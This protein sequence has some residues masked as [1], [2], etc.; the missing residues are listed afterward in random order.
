MIEEILPKIFFS[1]WIVLIVVSLFLLALAEAGYRI[2][3]SLHCKDEEAAGGQSGSV[4]GAVLGLLGLLLGFTFAMAAARL[5][6]RRGLLVSEANS[7]GTTW[8]RADFLQEPH[9]QEVKKLLIRYTQIKVDFFQAKSDREALRNS[10]GEIAQI[11]TQLWNHSTA[12]AAASPTPITASFITTLNET[13]DIDAT[14]KA[15]I[16][17]QV[18]GAVWTL[19]LVLAACGAWAS[20][21]SGGTTGIRS[22]FNQYAFPILIAVVITLITD[23]A[24]PRKGFVSINRE[25]LTD[26][27]KS[28]KP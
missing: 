12:A 9:K 19:L 8:L 11:H 1:Q 5:E 13:I 16:R 20:G 26:L 14:R 28:M 15:A 21:Y 24:Q 23:I 10:A 22:S 4:Q 27:L 25:P 6:D 3:Y 18:P 2:G 7:I 17:N